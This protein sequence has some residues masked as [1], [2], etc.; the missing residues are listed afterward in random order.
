VDLWKPWHTS[1]LLPYAK[2]WADHPKHLIDG[3][4][5]LDEIYAYKQR[6]KDKAA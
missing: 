1:K 6:I 4:F 5:F 3:L 2:G